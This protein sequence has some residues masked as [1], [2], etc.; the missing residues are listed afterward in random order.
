MITA[1]STRRAT[2]AS[3]ATV[4]VCAV[5]LQ[6]SAPAQ[7]LTTGSGKS[8]TES[9][10]VADFD[11]IALSG[12][13]QVEVRQSGKEAVSVTA[14]DNLLA[15][16][17]TVVENGRNGRTLH[18]RPKR[19]ESWRTRSEIRIA[20]DVARL[21]SISNAGSGRVQVEPLKTPGLKLSI[22]GSADTLLRG[23][24]TDSLQVS[25]AGSG[26]V[27][28]SGSATRLRLSIAGSGDAA[29][30]ELSADEVSIS[31]AGSGNA[32]V[33]ANKSLTATIA[34]SGDVRYRG[35]AADLK[36]T[37]MGSGTVRKE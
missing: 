12:A 23:L 19:G 34:G 33:T 9:R 35:S 29:L 8:V 17:E 5:G 21:S 14:D 16:I 31:I 30:A 28:G 4:L 24:Q 3:L 2:L 18:I 20:V 15:L 25:V 10:S 37:V 6:A 32:T 27:K 26:D 7:A 36:T 11:A 1:P 22:A 13:F